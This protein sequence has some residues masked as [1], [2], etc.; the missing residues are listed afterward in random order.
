M[1][2]FRIEKYRRGERAFFEEGT[3]LNRRPLCWLTSLFVSL[4]ALLSFP[5]LAEES[6]RARNSIIEE[7][8]VTAQKR[9]ESINDV[10]MS[11][12]ATSGEKLQDLGITDTADLFKVVSGFNSNV[13]Y[14][15]TS[16]YTIRGVGFQDTA[17][18]SGPTVSVYL[19]QMPLPFSALTQ[20]V[21]LDLQRVEVLKGPQGTL[22][23]QNSTGGAINYIANKPT[24][25]FESGINLSYGRFNEVDISGFVSGPISETLGYRLAVRNI[26]SDGWQ[27]ATVDNP[28]Q[29]PFWTDA[30]RNYTRSD[31]EWGEKDFSSYRA[32]LQ[33][34]PTDTFSALFSFSGF[35]D[36]SQSQAPQLYGIASLNPDGDL[37]PLIANYPRGGDDNRDADWGPCVN[38]AG[39]DPNLVFVQGFDN[40]SIGLS[41]TLVSTKTDVDGNPLN[42]NNRLYDF[43]E[44]AE[45]DNDYYNASLRMDWDIT[46]DITITSLTSYGEFNRDQQLESDG[47]FYQDYESSQD[48]FLDVIYQELRV[49]GSF[50][51]KGTW[52]VGANYEDTSTWDSFVQT[53]G[54]SSA[55][56]TL[57]NPLGPTNP[58]NRQ[59]TET[60]AVFASFDY[61]IRDDLIVQLGTRYTDQKRDYR[62]CGGD[63]GDG[64]WSDISE[65]IQEI[66]Q[67]YT[68]GGDTSQGT[69]NAGPGGCGSTGPAPTYHPIPT[70]FT[71]ELNEDNISWRVG[72]NWEPTPE[73]LYYVNISQGYKSGSFPTV[74]A[75][76]SLQLE[77][78]RQEDLLAYEVGTK[79]SLAN[80]RVQLNAA[81]FYYDYTDKQILAA[82]PDIIFGSLPALVN[83]PDSEVIGAEISLEWY[84]ID[85][86]RIAPSVS[87]SKS[88][89]KGTFDSFDPFFNPTNNAPKKDFSGQAF[90]NAPELQANIDL[91]YEWNVGDGFIAFV[92]MNANFQDETTG[93]FVDECKDPS[94]PCTREK[95]STACV[96]CDPKT[97]TP[98]FVGNTDLIIN[99]RLLIDLRAGIESDSWR[100]WFW[101]RNITDKYYWNQVAHVNDV[102]LRFTGAPRTYGVSASYRF[103]N[104]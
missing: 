51:G 65:G 86:L 50:R 84:P 85:G 37:N 39:G 82:V 53:Y 72:L 49:A 59:N 57:G 28:A 67:T 69:V 48:G 8:I 43:C 3:G 97:V 66:L 104:L 58:N 91:Q 80:G 30:G 26:T 76:A 9:E 77:P 41:N 60:W 52:V 73:S 79:L 17:L 68:A 36:E 25:E 15:G 92:G 4:S 64:T 70:G 62:G 38:V 21:I 6:E 100:V 101:G 98:N 13:T 47:T 95:S 103:G 12:Q 18:A 22:F 87:Y 96:I 1:G 45:R 99:E 46:D 20:G 89:T 35:I 71:N 78:T 75:A 5:V 10:G 14:Y 54:I 88:E 90:P 102:L 81:V 56:T 74:A 40:S 61:P 23:G 27:Q 55:I 19:D 63:A 32:S 7:V 34:D 42:L 44:D 83:V 31:D 16:I 11:I 33:W 24:T 2:Y 93:F 94:K 29:D